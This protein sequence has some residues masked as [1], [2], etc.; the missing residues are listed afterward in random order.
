[1]QKSYRRHFKRIH[2]GFGVVLGFLAQLLLNASVKIAFV[3][4]SNVP[5]L[6]SLESGGDQIISAGTDFEVNGDCV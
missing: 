4:F 2:V 3:R 1:M 6:H 5:G